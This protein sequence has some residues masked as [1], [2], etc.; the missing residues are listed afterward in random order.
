[1][2]SRLIISALSIALCLSAGTIKASAA[3][4]ADEVSFRFRIKSVNVDPK[5]NPNG[6]NLTKLDEL[7]GGDKAST[8]QRIELRASSSPEG[9]YFLNEL[10]AHQR[11][12]SVIK[13]ISERYPS[14]PASVWQ[15]EEVAEDWEGV[16]DYLRRS[17]EAY[18][19]EAMQIVRGNSPNRKELLQD[20]YAGEAWDDLY[21]YAF[22]WL[23]SVKLHIV[24]SEGGAQPQQPQQPQPQQPQPQQPQPQQP[25]PQQPQ[26]QQPQPQQPQPQQPQP[27]QPPV[28]PLTVEPIVTEGTFPVFFERS[29]ST[30]NTGFSSNARQLAHISQ[31]IRNGA[32][33]LVLVSYASPE[34]TEAVNM[35]IS[36]K[37]SAALRDYLAKQT[38]IPVEN[39]IIRDTGED[40]EGFTKAVTANYEGA[41]R[42]DVLRILKDNTLSQSAKEDALKKLN[43]GRT[44]QSLISNQMTELRRIEVQCLKKAVIEAP[45]I[46]EA[47]DIEVV[48]PEEELEVE[49]EEIQ[50]EETDI[51]VETIELP[52]KEPQVVEYTYIK[53]ILA[54]ST[55]LLYDAVTAFNLG[56]EV[57]IGPRWTVGVDAIYN[58]MNWPG[59]RKTSLL[60]GDLS[61]SYYFCNERSPLSGWF[62]TAGVGGGKY[63]LIGTNVGR[64]GYAYYFNMGG[65]Y[66]FILGPESSHWRLRLAGQVGPFQTKFKYSERNPEGNMVYKADK[67]FSWQLPTNLQVSL[68]YVFQTKVTT[69]K[70]LPQQ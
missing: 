16:A 62:L 33:S 24:Y 21:K 53:P 10:Y 69:Q 67:S 19:N 66:S 1:M 3:P 45:E 37:R 5:L 47:T 17:T 52:E 14:L 13:M 28:T 6:E 68:I 8:V 26:P 63:N 2:R 9:P 15:V 34:G 58:K 38:G 29:S 22:P 61:G 42:E 35:S 11:A 18:K 39:I 44:W 7:L 48:I 20:L 65:G 27:P 51:H 56:V 31:E 36:K 23:R 12:E 64:E 41:D 40:W 25:Q 50:I 57:P 59:D 55:N 32:D 70:T 46:P 60:G 49:E 54:L 43:G 30:L 4:A